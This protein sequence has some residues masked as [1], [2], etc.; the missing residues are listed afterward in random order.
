M[1]AHYMIQAWLIC[2]MSLD[3]GEGNNSTEFNYIPAQQDRSQPT[4]TLR[5][6]AKKEGWVRIIV[7]GEL[8]DVCPQCA[9]DLEL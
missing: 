1:S 3:C 2:D 9:V 7:D 6:A 8:K 5:G 4:R